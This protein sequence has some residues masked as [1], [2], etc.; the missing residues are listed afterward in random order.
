MSTLSNT[1]QLVYQEFPANLTVA[2]SGTSGVRKFIQTTQTLSGTQGYLPK[3]GD[4]WD[5]NYIEVTLK[6]IDIEMIDNCGTTKYVCSYD[7]TPFNQY[8]VVQISDDLPASIDI[9]G[10]FEVWKPVSESWKW[11]GTDPV[12]YV[13]Q[14]IV[15]KSVTGSI[16]LSRVIKNLDAYNGIVASLVNKVNGGTFRG[17][18]EETCMFT[19]AQETEFISRA[20]TKRWKSDMVFEILMCRNY[21]DPPDPTIYGWNNILNKTTGL[22]QRPVEVAHLLSLYELA[23]FDSLFSS[24]ALGDQEDMYQSI[25]KQDAWGH[26]IT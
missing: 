1:S 21:T 8:S 22:Y 18:P 7:S 4:S 16:K 23:D 25:P 11:F 10:Q 9:G 19:G 14:E 12:E 20:G 26:D 6:S 3:I 17:F 5:D 24:G 13:T 15:K 2:A